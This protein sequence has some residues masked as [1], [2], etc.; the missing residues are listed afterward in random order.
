MSK[1]FFIVCVGLSVSLFACTQS[2]PTDDSVGKKPTAEE[3]QSAEANSD[4]APTEAD[5]SSDS[6]EADDSTAGGCVTQGCSGELC[7][8]EAQFKANPVASICS[9]QEYYGCFSK[10][11]CRRGPKGCGWEASDDF[12][13]CLKAAGAPQG[14]IDRIK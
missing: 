2:N 13:A 4:I 1:Q 9:L 5:G 6:A 14:V 3:T 10:S 8:D 11:R 12:L 7:V